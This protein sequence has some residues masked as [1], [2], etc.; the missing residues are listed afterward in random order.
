[1]RINS[2]DRIMPLNLEEIQYIYRYDTI[3]ILDVMLKYCR[4]I[5]SIE[6]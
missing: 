2:G 6:I 4:R 1:M 3:E 5:N